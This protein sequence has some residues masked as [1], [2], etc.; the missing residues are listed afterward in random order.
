V[1][2]RITVVS[3]AGETVLSMLAIGMIAASSD[4]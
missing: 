4:A 3:H 2:T 1:R